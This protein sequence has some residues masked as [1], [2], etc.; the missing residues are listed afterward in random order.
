MAAF[1]EIDDV[2]RD[3]AAA[4]DAEEIRLRTE[5][6]RRNALMT[7][8]NA[9]RYTPGLKLTKDAYSAFKAEHGNTEHE[10]DKA[11]HR[12]WT[13]GSWYY[14]EQS[15]VWMSE[16][17][18]KTVRRASLA[19]VWD[20]WRAVRVARAE[21]DAIPDERLTNE[22][23]ND[24]GAILPR[25]KIDAQ[26][27]VERAEGLYDIV[28]RA[29]EGRAKRTWEQ[30]LTL[31]VKPPKQR[32]VVE[33]TRSSPTGYKKTGKYETRADGVRIPIVRKQ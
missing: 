3:L 30:A 29:F 31:R 21:Y 13:F 22:W 33:R 16:Q 27:A 25:R 19:Q 2:P 11:R 28:L 20:H 4:M 32:L 12:L 17:D 8:I 24:I 10:I 1:Y 6:K 15:R 14:S 7:I 18:D 23:G 5:I 9:S 26:I